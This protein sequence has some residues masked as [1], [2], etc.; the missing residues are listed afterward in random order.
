[1]A[2]TVDNSLG[3]SDELSPELYL[4]RF[5]V[6][7]VLGEGSYGKVKLC[8]DTVT[9]R[10]VAIKIIPKESLKKT[11][12]VTRLK[13]EVRIM[14]LLHHPNITRLYD[15]VETDSQIVL[16]M[17]H[18]Q[19]G[20]LFDYI[21]AQK[22]L[23]DRVARRLFRQIVSALEYC[24]RSSIIHRD[25]KPE[26]LLLDSDKNIKIIDFGFVKLFDKHECLQTFCGSPFYASPEMILGRQYQGPE[27]DIWSMG[28]IL[29]AL[30][31]GHLPFT[32]SNTTEL[33]KKIANGIYE[34]RTAYMS[35]DSADLIKR[36]LT[37]DASAR[38]TIAEIR[39]HRWVMQD[40]DEPP[41]SYI[42]DRAD[43]LTSPPDAN[44]LA[45]FPMYG[46]DLH[47][48]E[49]SLT[50]AENG[51]AWGLYHLL[52]EHEIWEQ[53]RSAE[54]NENGAESGPT[55]PTSP[56]ESQLSS[57]PVTS[58]GSL[59]TKRNIHKLSLGRVPGRLTMDSPRGPSTPGPI[60]TKNPFD[61]PTTAPGTA[62][63]PR[64]LIEGVEKDAHGS[65]GRRRA[66]TTANGHYGS[67]VD[68]SPPMSP[69]DK[70]DAEY[71]STSRSLNR[72][73]TTGGADGGKDS[74]SR[75][76]SLS[77]RRANGSERDTHS[78]K[79]TTP[80]PQTQMDGFFPP[81]AVPAP[82]SQQQQPQQ[83]QSVRRRGS[84]LSRES[85]LKEE[86]ASTV[87]R[88]AE[89]A[90]KPSPVIST[91]T[92]SSI[93]VN[94]T[95]STTTPSNSVTE[96]RPSLPRI[97]LNL[98]S[99]PKR[100]FR[101]MSTSQNAASPTNTSTPSTASADTT[102]TKPPGDIMAEIQRAMDACDMKYTTLSTMRIKGVG[103]ESTVEI[104]ICR[105]KGT[106][107]HALQMKRVK[108]SSLQ[109]Q[110]TC[111]NL[112]SRWHL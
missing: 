13:R 15:V 43:F 6:H 24:H 55:S 72:R 49:T 20:E 75:R 1:M 65:L 90:K 14:R 51:P 93:N 66:T 21:V 9:R 71:F 61:L 8:Y 5:K 79:P 81:T 44:I 77:R 42:P 74:L 95:S 112:I 57:S 45:K 108:G 91:P 4:D 89:S 103:R 70:T 30:L 102:S 38:I 64:S 110:A 99:L 101:R 22:R 69:M 16:T 34:T 105:I 39:N 54:F 67:V 29:F 92:H 11:A 40:N 32:D 58:G 28:V 7:K 59:K 85:T 27:V 78:A 88:N 86:H 26:N 18:V 56:P 10:M 76:N 37:V 19:G 53:S 107:I 73:K 106:D 97:G 84:L 83:F 109:Y 47:A 46:M 35:P 94:A 48:A 104:E 87:P 17:E 12:H 98:S 82:D 50:C 33:Y 31:N 111:Q 63:R 36:M 96:R 80:S 41:T 23:K 2:G 25:L 62:R 52:V 3:G 60:P 68:A 100:L